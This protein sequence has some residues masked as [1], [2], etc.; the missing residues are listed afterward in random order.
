L[1]RTERGRR[2]SGL[3]RSAPLT[4]MRTVATRRNISPS[5]VFWATTDA[6]NAVLFS[7]S[8]KSSRGSCR[9]GCSLEG[10]A[11]MRTWTMLSGLGVRK[12]NSESMFE[13]S[14]PR[15][16]PFF[17]AFA[18][19]L[20]ALRPVDGGGHVDDDIA[21]VYS[22]CHGWKRILGRPCYDRA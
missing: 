22:Q 9:E 4:A 19:S 6:I 7:E 21:P 10:R 20:N 17:L 1:A 14:V 18:I 3:R 16:L 8:V 2:S 15:F 5:F 11:S 13:G 12:A